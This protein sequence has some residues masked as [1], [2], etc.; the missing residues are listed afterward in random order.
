[1]ATNDV[2]NLTRNM[3]IDE[4]LLAS[5]K[6]FYSYRYKLASFLDPTMQM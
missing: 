3:L 1:M 6:F 2:I 4:V 5:L